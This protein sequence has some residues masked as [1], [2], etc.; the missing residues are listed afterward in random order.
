ML[1]AD[2]VLVART[3]SKQDPENRQ[4]AHRCGRGLQLRRGR[5]QPVR[6]DDGP[7]ARGLEA[8]SRRPAHGC[9]HI[10]RGLARSASG[11]VP[12]VRSAHAL[13]KPP[14]WHMVFGCE[15]RVACR[16][17]G[18]PQPLPHD[19][20][21]SPGAVGPAWPA[22]MTAGRRVSSIVRHRPPA[23]R[24]SLGPTSRASCLSSL[25]QTK[26][27]Y[28]TLDAC[29]EWHGTC[30]DVRNQRLHPWVLWRRMLS[31]SDT[32]CS[33]VSTVCVRRSPHGS[34]QDRHTTR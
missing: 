10:G 32:C 9:A 8:D 13:Q 2:G 6:Q 21:R 5:A 18:A 15:A 31:R 1:Q 24:S 22:R 23:P 33:L 20:V 17:R 16:R 34:D 27:F 29:S 11:C 3:L 30:S 26:S 4:V 7:R 25:D 28:P 12:P 19:G 14:T